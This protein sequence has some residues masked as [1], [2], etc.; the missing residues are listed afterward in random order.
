MAKKTVQA[1][2]APKPL[3]QFHCCACLHDFS[4]KAWKP[5]PECESEDTFDKNE[6]SWPCTVCRDE[7]IY[8]EEGTFGFVCSKCS[9][10]ETEE[11]E[12]E[13]LSLNTGM[14]ESWPLRDVLTR[15]VEAA[16]HL[17]DVH[18]CDGHGH[19]GIRDAVNHG[20]KYLKLPDPPGQ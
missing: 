12:S 14:G 16:E 4:A 20:R 6:E 11:D 2:R 19:E 9:P 5:C 8:A 15:L 7:S 1:K 17:L 13:S 18:N 10:P 3:L